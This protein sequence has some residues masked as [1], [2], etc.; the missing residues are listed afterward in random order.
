MNQSLRNNEITTIA[1]NA[2]DILFCGDSEGSIYRLS[3]QG[4]SWSCIKSINTRI[5]EI[6]IDSENTI[7]IGADDGIHVSQNFG[8][9]WTKIDLDG[10]GVYAIGASNHDEIYA[11]TYSGIY[12]SKDYGAS[13]EFSGLGDKEQIISIE[14]DQNGNLYAGMRDHTVFRSSDC[15]ETWEK[16]DDGIPYWASIQSIVCANNGDIYAASEFAGIYKSTNEGISWEQVS[17]YS[18]NVSMA[19]Y[20]GDFILVGSMVNGLIISSDNGA[21]WE[22][23]SI[24]LH[25]MTIRSIVFDSKNHLYVCG[26]KSGIYHHDGT[27]WSIFGLNNDVIVKLIIND[28]DEI[29]AL[30]QFE[31]LKATK[32]GVI[33]EQC[34]ASWLGYYGT[35][36][37]I[38]DTGVL[39]CTNGGKLYKSKDK[40]GK[41]WV[42]IGSEHGARSM[43]F[44]MNHKIYTANDAGFFSAMDSGSEWKQLDDTA[45]TQSVYALAV[46]A[47]Q[48]IFWGTYGFGVY[49][50]R[51]D[52][53]SL[54]SLGLD[55]YHI[56][57]LIVTDNDHI[58][59]SAAG[60]GVFYSEDNGGTWQKANQGLSDHVIN[61]LVQ[62]PDGKIYAG[63]VGDGLY[64]CN[65][66]D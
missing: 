37:D 27:G 21:N 10:G 15:G 39:F 50:Y 34:N 9:D 29:M 62:G 38:N 41:N 61:L 7:Y 43:T 36:L 42:L 55:N 19:S 30:T 63:T 33:W 57:S 20:G 8:T 48:E 31:G 22:L 54:E 5:N 59:V 23:K 14:V 52:S 24:G 4:K 60:D 12:V 16:R 26:T 65:D 49:R 53:D 2:S 58:F 47:N 56:T 6:K 45:Y 17:T 18:H 11:G 40:S 13:W 25:A 28:Y 64:C 35:S 44:G 32:D 1:V 51:E 46:N 66:N 3:A